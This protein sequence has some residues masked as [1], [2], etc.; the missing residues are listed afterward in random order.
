MSRKAVP[1][2]PR[3]RHVRSPRWSSEANAKVEAIEPYFN[4]REKTIQLVEPE[5]WRKPVTE[6]APILEELSDF[7][8]THLVRL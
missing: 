1:R 6:I 2:K 5:P 8:S 7:F 4:R 3:T